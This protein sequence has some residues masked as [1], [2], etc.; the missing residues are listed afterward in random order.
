[1]KN[2]TL[3]FATAVLI[4]TLIS[5]GCLC[6]MAAT[7]GPVPISAIY[8]LSM[9]EFRDEEHGAYFLKAERGGNCYGYITDSDGERV[10][11]F[12]EVTYND[13]LSATPIT[14][15]G[16]SA[17]FYADMVYDSENSTLT[18]TVRDDFEAINIDFTELVFVVSEVDNSALRPYDLISASWSDENAIFN[19][20]ATYYPYASRTCI[21][22]CYMLNGGN[23]IYGA[24]DFVWYDGEFKI[25]D[26]EECIASGEYDFDYKHFA[27]TLTFSTDDLFGEDKPFAS[28]PALILY[29]D[30]TAYYGN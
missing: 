8:G 12:F 6:S 4:I 14:R 23:V 19:L 7:C 5:F 17:C 20:S 3:K 21:L 2:R 28:Y 25:F 18:C 27:V 9:V 29:T 26:G 13:I 30:W 16:E 15:S 11:T 10:E 1:M 22:R 24:Y